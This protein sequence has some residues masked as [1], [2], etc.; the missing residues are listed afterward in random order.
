M[1]TLLHSTQILTRF[2]RPPS[3]ASR[4]GATPGRSGR[5]P[6]ETSNMSFVTES[7]RI[8]FGIFCLLSSLLSSPVPPQSSSSFLRSAACLCFVSYSMS[9][10]AFLPTPCMHACM[11][12]VPI[13]CKYSIGR[14]LRPVCFFHWLLVHS[15]ACSHA[16]PRPHRPLARLHVYMLPRST[17][18]L[19]SPLL[20]CV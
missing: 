1:S 13:Q 10:V 9:S 3:I 17:K 12:S 20:A 19:P 11:C 15:S 2:G 6:F 18:S 7:A 16:V 8:R 4:C 5:S 14:V